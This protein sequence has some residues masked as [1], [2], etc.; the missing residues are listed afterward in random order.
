[1]MITL[2]S[3]VYFILMVVSTFFF[4]LIMAIFGWFLPFTANSKIANAWGITNSFFLKNVCGLTYSI[5]GL[6]NLPEDRACIIMSKH[7]S[8]WETI[9]FRGIFPAN[10]AWVLKRELMYVPIFGWAL[11]VVQPIAINRKAG[12]QAMKQVVKQGL[13]RLS[14]NRNVIIFPEGTRV[15]PGEKKRYGIGGGLLA[16]KADVPVIPVAHNAGVFWKRRG[17]K[18]YPGNIEV[19]VG[20]PIDTTDMSAA[21]I[22]R[23]VEEWI[24]SEMEKLPSKTP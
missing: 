23:K 4:G 3:S 5:K 1:M 17:L 15:A 2:R 24:E 7:Q 16:E 6:E 12:R 11:A 20:S 10:Q 14:Q 8:A 18:K 21:D 13:L 9:T 19:V 22:T